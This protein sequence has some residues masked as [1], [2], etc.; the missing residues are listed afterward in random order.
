MSSF[1]ERL[2]SLRKLHNLKAEELAEIVGVKRR[3]I[4][5][6]EK[7]DSN[8]SYDVLI[9]LADYFKVS[10]DYLVGRSDKP[11]KSN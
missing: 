1:G 4:F 6:Y 9:A 8:P 7:N 2:R 10:L 5:M 3:I 11:E